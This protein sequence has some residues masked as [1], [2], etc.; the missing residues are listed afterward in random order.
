MNRRSIAAKRGWLSR[1]AKK[2]WITRREREKFRNS[3][4]GQA[5]A[6]MFALTNEALPK[7]REEAKS[8]MAFAVGTTL[9]IKMPERLRR[10]EIILPL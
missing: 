6:R 3:P 9:N 8:D 4:M 10:Q 7:I 5:I 1:R 2:G